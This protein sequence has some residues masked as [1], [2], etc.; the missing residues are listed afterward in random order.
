MGLN[1]R[2][3]LFLTLAPGPMAPMARAQDP[4]VPHGARFWLVAAALTGA[5]FAVDRSLHGFAVAHQSRSFNRAAQAVDPLGRAEYLVP[6][7]VAAATVPAMFGDWPLAKGALRIGAGYVA[8]D[9]A[10]GAL[11]VA[12]GRH[13]P[14]STGNQWR[15][16]PFHP[17]GDW[18]SMPSAHVTHAFAIAAGIAEESGR[19]WAA[20]LAYGVASLVAAQRVYRQAHWA[21]DVA[22]GATLSV[23]VSRRI[24]RLLDR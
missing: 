9:L 22:V 19:P 2:L 13:R 10:G 20:G 4:F 21:S 17:E 15:F 8:A 18:G 11:R 12:V 7:L 16:R 14:D 5:G 1:L 6:S 24:V 23:A 3:L